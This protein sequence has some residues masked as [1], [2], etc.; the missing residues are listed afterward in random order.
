MHCAKCGMKGISTVTFLDKEGARLALV[1]LPCGH[2]DYI[3]KG[4]LRG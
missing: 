3:P 4:A 1:R 2:E